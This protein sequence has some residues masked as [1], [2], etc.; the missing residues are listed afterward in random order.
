[1]KVL[2]TGGAG[3]IGSHVVDALLAQGHE[4]RVLDLVPSPWHDAGLETVVA[5][6][7]DTAAVSEAVVGCDAVLHLAAMA[8]VYQVVEEP[9][10]H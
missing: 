4:P 3:F 1:M 6:L 8:D 9:G 7:Q 10:R 5:D 2:V